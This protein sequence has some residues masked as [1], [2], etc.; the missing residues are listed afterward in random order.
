M[1]IVSFYVWQPQVKCCRDDLHL[2]IGWAN[3]MTKRCTWKC[4]PEHVVYLYNNVVFSIHCVFNPGHYVRIV[5]AKHNIIIIIILTVNNL[6]YYPK[7]N[8]TFQWNNKNGPI[9]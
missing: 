7:P 9:I 1:Y 8:T 2:H 3:S 5:N 4:V 6:Y